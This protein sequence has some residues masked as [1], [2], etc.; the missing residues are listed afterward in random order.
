MVKRLSHGHDW[1]I[2]VSLANPQREIPY[3]FPWTSDP[4]FF[5]L[6]KTYG[7]STATWVSPRP[8]PQFFQPHLGA[9]PVPHPLPSKAPGHR[10]G[11]SH[12]VRHPQVLQQARQQLLGVLTATMDINGTQGDDSDKHGV[13]FVGWWLTYLSQK[14]WSS[15]VG[16]ILPNIWKVIKAMFQ[17]TNQILSW[18]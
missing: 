13:V 4:P 18:M 2:W 3:D 12:D 15:S 7:F 5:F 8:N 14:S 11:T 16:I 9:L 1:M 17:S 10:V 6:G